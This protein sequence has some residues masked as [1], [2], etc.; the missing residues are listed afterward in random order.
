MF[1]VVGRRCRAD[2]KRSTS[3]HWLKWL[4][5]VRSS[6]KVVIKSRVDHGVDLSP[7]QTIPVN[8]ISYKRGL[9]F[10]IF[11]IFGMHEFGLDRLLNR[12]DAKQV[13]PR[14]FGLNFFVKILLNLFIW[15]GLLLSSQVLSFNLFLWC[16]MS[17]K[18]CI[19]L[20]K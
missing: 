18:S 5:H 8:P 16:L 7:I 1:I 19:R 3:I 9:I 17:I 12:L 15:V 20:F 14:H 6:L 4:K 11:L 10:T 13:E 2:A